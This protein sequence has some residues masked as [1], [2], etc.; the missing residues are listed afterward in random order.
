MTILQAIVS[1]SVILIKLLIMNVL[2]KE[3]LC[4]LVG[5]QLVNLQTQFGTDIN[6]VNS[7][8]A[9]KCTYKN[10]SVITN[11]NQILG[12]LCECVYH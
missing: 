6:N 2:S 5:G 10:I 11:D 1:A 8:Q 7:T 3:E 9:C 12:C 4:S